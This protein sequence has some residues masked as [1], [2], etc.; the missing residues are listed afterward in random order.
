MFSHGLNVQEYVRH[1]HKPKRKASGVCTCEKC[2]SSNGYFQL[3]VHKCLDEYPFSQSPLKRFITLMSLDPSPA[4]CRIT[5]VQS[6]PTLAH[7]C[8]T[9][10]LIHAYYEYTFDTLFQTHAT[11]K[12]DERDPRG[13]GGGGDRTAGPSSPLSKAKQPECK[14]CCGFLDCV[15]SGQTRVFANAMG[16]QVSRSLT[17]PNPATPIPRIS[18]KHEPT[19][20]IGRPVEADPSEDISGDA[21]TRYVRFIVGEKWKPIIESIR[22]MMHS[23]KFI[24]GARKADHRE[25]TVSRIK[26]AHIQLSQFLNRRS[27]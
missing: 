8:I 7:C 17:T 5:Y 24:S 27:V 20:Y 10:T 6:G 16:I 1:P 14:M 4:Y 23:R 25:V 11:Q 15:H 21:D 22:Y 18:T 19:Y 2:E 3:L 26:E 9:G 12:S 13:G